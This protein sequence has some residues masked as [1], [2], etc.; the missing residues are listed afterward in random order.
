MS[1]LETLYHTSPAPITD[2]NDGGLFGS[3]L[4]FAFGEY[5]MT[6]VEDY[7]TYEIEIDM[8]DIIDACSL[9][10]HENAAALAPFTAQV[11]RMAGVDEETADNLIS[12]RT[13]IFSVESDVAP[14]DLAEAAWEIQRITAEAAV[15]LGFRGVSMTDEQGGMI[16]LDMFGREN[17]LRRVR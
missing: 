15:A 8:N 6:A 10:Y 12:E 3:F 13:D 4:C 14:E 9:F 2:I 11:M 16:M 7:V 1:N 5:V 17:E